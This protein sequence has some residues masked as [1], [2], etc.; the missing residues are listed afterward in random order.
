MN[1]KC[2]DTWNPDKQIPD[3]CNNYVHDDT[4]QPYCNKCGHYK[5]C[6]KEMNKNEIIEL[7][8]EIEDYLDGRIDIKDSDDG[9]VPNTAMKLDGRIKKMIK[10][11]DTE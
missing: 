9:P 7:L 6:H 8:H 3:I 11:L 2:K 10:E 5:E 4:Y 1:C